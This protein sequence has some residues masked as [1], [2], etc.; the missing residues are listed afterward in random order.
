MPS[1]FD[2][3][4]IFVSSELYNYVN[5][6]KQKVSHNHSRLLLFILTSV[7][8]SSSSFLGSPSSLESLHEDPLLQKG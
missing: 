7:T 3:A 4:H 5:P 6:F 8:V 2:E 1:L